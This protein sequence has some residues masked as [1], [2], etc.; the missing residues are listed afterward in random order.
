MLSASDYNET[1][2]NGE[3]VGG[4]PLK[5]WYRNLADFP[6]GTG[7][8]YKDRAKKIFDTYNLE[9]KKVL[10]IGCAF[11]FTVK[12]LREFGADAYGID[13]S[14]YAVGVANSPYVTLADARTHAKSLKVNE[15]D[16][17]IMC[18][19]LHCLTDEDITQFVKDVGKKAKNFF[20]LERRDFSEE[21]ISLYNPK[22]LTEWQTYF[23]QVEIVWREEESKWQLT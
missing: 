15:Y 10:D 7:E 22:L 13:F 12:D 9:G 18:E 5:R 21:A 8:Y 6:E 1:Y 11:G 14:E 23:P 19:F 17:I 16:L 2:F 20:I 3:V 4:Y